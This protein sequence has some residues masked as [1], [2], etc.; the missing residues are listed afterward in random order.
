MMPSFTIFVCSTFNDLSHEREGVLD[1]I[2]RLKLQHDS[3]EFFGA[4]AEQ[5]IETCL[6]EV[7]QAT[8]LL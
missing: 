8:S 2:R 6:L 3:M 7:E 1:A 4:R 5:P